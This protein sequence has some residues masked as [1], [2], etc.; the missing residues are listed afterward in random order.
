[1]GG[2]TFPEMFVVL[3]IALIVFGPR[4]L[5]ELGKSLGKA[6]AQFKH[7]SEEFKRSW[8]DEIEAE[9]KQPA[10]TSAS[11]TVTEPVVREAPSESIHSVPTEKKREE[12][13]L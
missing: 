8:V 10:I 5:P 4:K 6:L 2:I 12:N 13:W 3:V 1:M 7:A 9:K 11:P